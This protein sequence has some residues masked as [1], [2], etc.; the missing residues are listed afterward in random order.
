MLYTVEV[1][2]GIPHSGGIKESAVSAAADRAP[3]NLKCCWPGF[4]EMNQ[5]P[6]KMYREGFIGITINNS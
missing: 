2:F 5:G 3:L 1:N 4:H 6:T